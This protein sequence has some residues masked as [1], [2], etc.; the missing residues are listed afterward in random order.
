MKKFKNLT[1]SEM[2][3]IL[4]GVD[5]ELENPDGCGG[6]GAGCSSGVS[7]CCQNLSCQSIPKVGWQCLQ[8]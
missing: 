5:A 4:G 3:N 8:N 7:T 6:I 1:K 2:K